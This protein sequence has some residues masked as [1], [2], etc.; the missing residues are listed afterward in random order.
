MKVTRRR[1]L[2]TGSAAVVGAAC[3]APASPSSS[4]TATA[5]TSASRAPT[6][7]TTAAV[8][9]KLGVL[10]PYTE[11][12]VNG[13]IGA[14][15]KKAF[16]LYLKQHGNALGGRP[17]RSVWSDESI[18]PAFNATKLQLLL[19]QEKVEV[20]LG[21]GSDAT[22]Y[23]IRDAAARVKI[24][25]ID[26]NATGNALTRAIADCKPSCKSAFVFRTSATTWQLTDPFGQWATSLGGPKQYFAVH[27]DSPFGAEAVAG[28]ESGIGKNTGKLT[29]R[30]AV[31]PSTGDWGKVIAQIKAQ[32]TKAIFAVFLTDDA[33]AFLKAWAAAGLGGD[34]HRLYGPGALTDQQVLSLSQR[35]GIGATT[36]QLWSSQV[37]NAETKALV[38]AFR[39]EYTDEDTG[40]PLT[41]DA[42]AVQMWDALLA[43]DQALTMT[44]GDPRSDLLIPA[45]EG[46]SIRGP[47][48]TL[49]FDK[50]THGFV[51]DIYIC[52]VRASGEAVVNAIIDRLPKIADP[53]R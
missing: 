45:L 32:P 1:F 17:V 35:S 23:A 42:F 4:S 19:E 15:Q 12:A 30:A 7:A 40:G 31:P 2:I 13:D 48:G 24:V 36:S 3:S 16:D 41:P 29:G 22:A 21:G 6:A 25:Y 53:G 49:A 44:K 51:Q 27:E 8:P 46:V 18:D 38:D 14:A 50:V 10:I 26:T 37:D 28:F 34:G 20:V 47:R 33:V 39:T 52:E 11:Q 43:L 9:L 5:A